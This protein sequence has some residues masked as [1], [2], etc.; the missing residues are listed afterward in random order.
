EI[1]EAEAS[2]DNTSNSNCYVH[3]FLREMKRREKSGEEEGSF[4]RLQLDKAAA[5]MWGAGFETTVTTLRYAIHYLI[6]HPEVQRKMQKEIDEAVGDKVT[7][8]VDQKSLPYCCA[9]IQELQR[10]ANIFPVN[11]PRQV[12]FDVQVQGFTLR[13]GTPVVPQFQIVHTDPAEFERPDYFCPERF[14]NEKGEFVKDPRI[15]PFSMGKRACIG[16]NL[17]RLELFVFLTT[18]VQHI[19]FSSPTVVPPKLETSSGF[20]RPPKPFT[21]VVKDRTRI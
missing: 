14:V 9:V 6:N 21:V 1:Q 19:E 12:A 2:D 20:V 17:A 11:L 5:D 15:T 16:E 8:Y 3:S 4:T 10:I 18:F 7:R 13:T